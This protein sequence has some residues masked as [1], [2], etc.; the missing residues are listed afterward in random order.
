MIELDIP[1]VDNLWSEKEQ[2]FMWFS[3]YKVK[4]EHSLIAVRKWEAKWHKPFLDKRYE[5]TTAELLD[6]ISCMSLTGPLDVVKLSQMPP[7]ILQKLID[8]IENPSTA[9]TFSDRCIGAA[10]SNKEVITA[11]TIYYWMIIYNIPVEFE[12]WHLE[13]LLALI[14][15]VSIKMNG[16][17]KKMN[18]QDSMRYMAAQNAARREKYKTK[19]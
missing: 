7:D 3:P 11:E 13:S 18:A 12:K 10:K 5:K 16:S 8:Y 1:G 9:A 15:F 4:L 6:Y 19:G 2:K 14:K 17:R